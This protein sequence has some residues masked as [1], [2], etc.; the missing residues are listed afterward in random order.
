MDHRRTAAPVGLGVGTLLRGNTGGP[1]APRWYLYGG[2]VL[3]TVLGLIIAFKSR[4][5]LSTGR[6]LFCAGV[7]TLGACLAL[8]AAWN[9]EV[10]RAGARIM[11]HRE[12]PE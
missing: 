10:L 8:A 12:S 4:H 1:T 9:E 7:V 3:L 6:E 2:D 11:S 5:P